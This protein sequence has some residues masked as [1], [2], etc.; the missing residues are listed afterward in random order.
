MKIRF[1]KIVMTGCLLIGGFPMGS[2]IGADLEAG[3]QLA[4]QCSA[5]HGADGVSTGNE[6]PNL[7]SQKESYIKSQLL[8]F[9]NDDRKNPLMNAIAASLSETDIENL[10]AHFAS[11]PGAEPG[12]IASNATGLDGQLPDFPADIETSFTRY[13]RIDFEDR[14]QVRYYAAN[15]IALAAAKA[16][17]KFPEGSYLLVEIYD[18][19]LDEDD[20]LVYGDDDLLVPKNRSAYTAM[21]KRKDWGKDVPDVLRNDDWRYAVFTLDGKHRDNLNEGTCLACHKPLSDTD[22]SFTYDTLKQFANTN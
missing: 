5:C 15:D 10:A 2:A 21:E 16:G 14:K 7:A 1:K 20:N 9:K 19:M 11:L 12:E 6:F 3:S 22:Y 18:A 4:T 17:D 13:Q 8:A